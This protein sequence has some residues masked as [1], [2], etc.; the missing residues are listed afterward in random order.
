MDTKTT[1]LETIYA[2]YAALRALADAV[3]VW[4][5]TRR[6]YED[7]VQSDAFHPMDD[8]HFKA[9]YAAA[10]AIDAAHDWLDKLD[11]LAKP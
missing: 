10:E 1:A 9:E 8:T 5:E 3:G 6:R 11:A 2:E 7:W 4:R